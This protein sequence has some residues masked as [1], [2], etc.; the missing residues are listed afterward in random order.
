MRLRREAVGDE[1]NNF[2]RLKIWDTNT[3]DDREIT[4]SIRETT[5]RQ[6]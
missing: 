1:H 4:F 6:A 3:V 2:H 5:S